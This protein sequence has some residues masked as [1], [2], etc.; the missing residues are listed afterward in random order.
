MYC[1]KKSLLNTKVEH[2]TP[3]DIAAKATLLVLILLGINVSFF[4]SL[5]LPLL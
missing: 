5:H 1:V 3:M 2:N 4:R